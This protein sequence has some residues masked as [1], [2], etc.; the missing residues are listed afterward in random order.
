MSLLVLR[1]E[2]ILATRDADVGNRR[3]DY[4]FVRLYAPD[5]KLDMTPAAAL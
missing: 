5:T 1:L 4:F 3:G 2:N